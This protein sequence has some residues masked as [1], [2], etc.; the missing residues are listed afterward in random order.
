MSEITTLRTPTLASYAMVAALVLIWGN[1]FLMVKFALVE[2]SALQVACARVLVGAA[3]VIPFAIVTGRAMPKGALRWIGA[4]SIGV[5]SLALPMTLLS[6]AQQTVPSG[7][8]GVYM[9]VIPLLVL[10][11][12]H[13]F[14]PGETMTRTKAAGFLIGFTGVLMLLGWETLTGIG[15]ASAAGQLAC[16][17][18]ALS[19]AI[20]SIM[21]RRTPATDPIALSALGFA[22]AAFLMFPYAIRDWPEAGTL[23]GTTWAILIGIGVVS[24]GIA[25]ILRTTIITTVGSVFMSGVGYLVP[26]TALAV[27][28]LF[29]GET[30]AWTDALACALILSG[31][32]IA[33]RRK[34]R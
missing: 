30:L 28:I 33:A 26:I 15:S 5:F 10:P 22:F 20:G 8:A 7:I 31:L 32:A 25:M 1:T 3:A 2:A 24:S 14:S 6:W 18:A 29:G 16:L 21:T 17:G 11:L 34:S 12:A 9:A 4:G 19:Y 23:S 27:G 13:L